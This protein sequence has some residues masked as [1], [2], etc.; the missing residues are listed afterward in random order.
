MFL[1]NSSLRARIMLIVA[2]VFVG[3][4]LLFGTAIAHLHEEMLIARKLKAQQ[5]TETAYSLIAHYQAEAVAGR[6]TVEQAKREAIAELRGLRYGVNDY[7]WISD[8]A[9]RMVMHP[10]SP[11]LDGK[12]LGDMTTPDGRHLFIDMVDSVKA[13]GADFTLYDWPK[14]GTNQPVRKID[15]IKGFQPWGWIVGT[16]IYLD[17]FDATFRREALEM[18]GAA[19]LTVLGATALSLLIAARFTAPPLQR[20]TAT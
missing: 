4:A 13:R 20:V 17:D 8:M 7:F 19:L 5:L 10:I 18:G 11:E 15:Y 6:L 12:V 3:A 2:A 9:T 14:P 1:D 16:G